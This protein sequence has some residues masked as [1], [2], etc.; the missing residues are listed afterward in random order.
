[1][2]SAGGK[3]EIVDLPKVGIKGNSHLQMMDKNNL[4]VAEF[5]QAWLVK[6]G[7]YR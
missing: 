3:L 5:I 4:D 6:Q 1:V 7:L 2:K